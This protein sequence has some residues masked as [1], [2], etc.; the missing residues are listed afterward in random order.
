VKI[1]G[2]SLLNYYG[3]FLQNVTA[4]AHSLK[5]CSGK[6]FKNLLRREDIGQLFRIADASARG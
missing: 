4:K 2:L 3:K 1:E 5:S 6:G